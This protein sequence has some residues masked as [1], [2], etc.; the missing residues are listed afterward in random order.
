MVVLQK[1][2]ESNMDSTNYTFFTFRGYYG[3][4]DPSRNELNIY[5]NELWHEFVLW[6]RATIGHLPLAVINQELKK[7]PFD[8]TISYL[9]ESYELYTNSTSYIIS[10]DLKNNIETDIPK[11]F[12]FDTSK[13]K[14]EKCN[15]EDLGS[16]TVDIGMTDWIL[17]DIGC[18]NCYSMASM[19][20]V[21][22]N[23]EIMD[24][25]LSVSERFV[26]H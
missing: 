10:H 6:V 5:E 4:I 3:I 25:K 1:K 2:V 12:G 14:C 8:S 21:S 11:L 7:I 18:P 22:W 19:G 17:Y 24:Y 13:F 15:W 16:K 26:S 20:H 23:S 9:L